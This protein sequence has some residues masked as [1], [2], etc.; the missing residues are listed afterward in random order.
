[1]KGQTHIT[2]CLL[3]LGLSIIPVQIAGAADENGQMAVESAGTYKLGEVVVTAP[4]SR[5]PLKVETDPKAPRQPIPAHDGADYLK[6]IPGFSVIRKGGTDGDPVFRGM[7]GSRLNILLDGEEILGGCGM[8]MDPPTAYVFPGS[9]DQITVLKGPQTVLYGPGNSAGVVLFERDVKRFKEPGIHVNSSITLGSFGRND[10]ML[11]LRAGNPDGYAQI[12]GTRSHSGDYKDGDGNKVHSRYT[13]WSA[14]AALGWTPSDDTLL[15]LTAAKSDG[16]AAYADR[17]M[18]GSKFARDNFGLKFKQEHISSLLSSFEAQAYYN[19]VDHVMDNYSLRTFTPTMMMANP[20]ANNPDR[21][22]IGGKIVAAFALGDSTDAHLGFDYQSNIHTSRITM[23]QTMTPYTSKPR[24]E[25]AR[26]RNYGLFGD[27]TH[28]LGDNDR[29]LAGLRADKWHAEDKRSVVT[30]MMGTVANPT[31]NQVRNDT[32]TS[33]F[34]RYEHDLADAPTTLYVGVGYTSRFPDYWE[35]ISKESL[36]TVSAF[37]TRVEKTMQFDAGINYNGEYATASISAFYS[38][39]KDFNLIQSG[40]T[41]GMRTTTVNRNIDA[42]TWGG[43]FSAAYLLTDYWKVDGTASYVYGTND[44]DNLALGQMPPLEGRIGLNYDD[45]TYS[46]GALL[47][48]AAAQN[49]FAA[50]QGNIVGQDIGR[51][52]GFGVLSLHGGWRA[53][54]N[55]QL[56]AGV[57]NLFDKTYAEHISRSGSSVPGYITTTR[58]NE[59]GRS[60]WVSG[61]IIF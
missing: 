48:L 12:S 53:S 58:V 41:K 20:A 28:D 4:V 39:I 57:D 43:E 45:K 27:V 32:L 47:R 16:E 37:N 18:D 10:E 5:E 30:L 26:F 52:G 34:A 25:D 38:K 54:D 8:R 51:T 1:M 21:K 29:L 13:R 6:N 11:D 59:M 22:T 23:N 42:T 15:E 31:A 9:Y 36:T 55:I 44:T 24:V 19:Y 7:A 56:T 61:N 50:N 2:A 33:G 49:R 35:L 17:S 60:F 40:I 14:N 46:A 3:A